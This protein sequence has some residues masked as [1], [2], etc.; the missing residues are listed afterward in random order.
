MARNSTP[1]DAS[2]TLPQEPGASTKKSD[3]GTAPAAPIGAAKILTWDYRRDLV[4][5]VDVALGAVF[6][7]AIG[8]LILLLLQDSTPR[9]AFVKPLACLALSGALFVVRL[10]RRIGSF[11]HEHG[12][13]LLWDT[14]ILKCASADDAGRSQQ[15]SGST[16]C[17]MVRTEARPGDT[18]NDR[19]A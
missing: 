14:P 19:P 1:D 13:E 3:S 2:P 10:S 16:P 5:L 11:R 17:S 12:A 9:S 4:L 15:P 8:L 18:R 7:L 6:W